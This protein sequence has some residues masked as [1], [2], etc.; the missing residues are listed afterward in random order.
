MD[1]LITDHINQFAEFLSKED[2]DLWLLPK[3]LDQ[4]AT[5][6][7]SLASFTYKTN[8]SVAKDAFR[9]IAKENLKRALETYLFEK[10]HWRDGREVDSYLRT[11]INRVANIEARHLEGAATFNTLMCP[12]CKF[13]HRR[14]PLIHQDGY[15][16]CPECTSQLE[17]IQEEVKKLPQQDTYRMRLESRFSLFRAFSLHSKKGFR[18]PDCSRFIPESVVGHYG[19]SCPYPDC[20]YFGKPEALE[21]MNHPM[22]ITRRLSL[23]LQAP[24]QEGM[25][26]S[27]QSIIPAD[28]L[29]SDIKIEV[30]EKIR[31][32]YYML[33]SVI[34]EQLRTVEHVSTVGTILQKTLMYEAYLKM[35]ILYPADMVSYLVHCKVHNDFP[36]QAK[37]FQE[38]IK[39]VQDTLPCKIT[40]LGREHEIISLDDPLLGLFEGISVFRSTVRGNGVIPNKTKETYIGGTSYKDYGPC[41]IGMVIDIVDSIGKSL[42][43]NIVEYGFA[44]IQMDDSIPAGAEVEVKHY[45]I[46]SHYEMGSLVFL[47]R[48]RRSI[49][50]KVYLKT[51]GKK[52]GLS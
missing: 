23:S 11:V 44:Q 26:S 21:M 2:I 19:V 43:Q 46:P 29:G 3:L 12:A 52:R 35:L 36:I 25:E 34:E 51:Y 1:I 7:N 9:E 27:I 22:G 37:I 20:M 13:L 32:E 50:D 39:L 8:N 49:V 24:V 33:K 18:C 40:K 45:R 15:W 4:Y 41:F 31:D 47:Q 6:I 14:E 16:K 10:E 28:V 30:N 5:K 48:I 38:Y 42:K 17:F